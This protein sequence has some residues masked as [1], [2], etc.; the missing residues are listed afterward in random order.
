MYRPDTLIAEMRTHRLRKQKTKLLLADAENRR[1]RIAAILDEW[2]M[3]TMTGYGPA[4]TQR[5]AEERKE[6]RRLTAE[7][8]RPNGSHESD[9]GNRHIT[10]DAL[11]GTFG[12]CIIGG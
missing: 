10:G 11:Q 6:Q 3:K 9:H 8:I 7:E 12:V 5:P 2:A 1:L 4:T